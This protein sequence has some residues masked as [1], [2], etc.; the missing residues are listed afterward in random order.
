MYLFYYKKACEK[1]LNI[2]FSGSKPLKA[3]EI[4]ETLNMEKSRIDLEHITSNKTLDSAL[5]LYE[6]FERTYIAHTL[7][8]LIEI[9]LIEDKRLI[10][11]TLKAIQ[12]WVSL[13]KNAQKTPEAR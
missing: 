4:A 8:R 6:N 11:V 13:S 7:L 9:E 10:G 3:I 2:C 5:S 12:Q 1:N